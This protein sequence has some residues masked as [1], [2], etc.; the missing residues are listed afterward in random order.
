MVFVLQRG[1]AEFEL[2]CGGSLLN[3][4]P[5]IWSYG[6]GI[7]VILGVS[8]TLGFIRP[9]LP[10]VGFTDRPSLVQTHTHANTLKSMGEVRGQT[11]T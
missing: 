7:G 2:R 6:S 5:L 9:A 11:N 8:C 10:N 1:M 3:E 4:C